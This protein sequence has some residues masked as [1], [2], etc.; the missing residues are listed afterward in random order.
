VRAFAEA[1]RGFFAADPADLGAVAVLDQLCMSAPG[2]VRMSRIR[3]GASTLVA[4]LEREGGFAVEH[5][6]VLRRVAHDASGI[7]VTIESPAGSHAERH[8]DYVVLT[9]PPPLLLD[10]EFSPPLPERARQALGRVTMGPGTKVL[11]RFRSAW[12]KKRGRP[13]AFGTNLPIGAVWDAG[14]DQKGAAVLTLFAAGSASRALQAI[15]AVRGTRGLLDHLRWLGRPDGRPIS[16]MQVTWERDPWARGVY[17]VFGPGF[18]PFDRELLGRAVG[19]VLLA[20]EHT[21]RHAQGYMEG[22][23]ESGER[24]AQEVE[25]FHLLDRHA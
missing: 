11:L 25:R 8:A 17:A 19:R 13:E 6:S 10:V 16:R 4:A 12:W 18:D 5:R 22:A 3:G 1:L 24:V 9:L 21:S 7:H 2:A 15:A 20:G 23:L 14:S